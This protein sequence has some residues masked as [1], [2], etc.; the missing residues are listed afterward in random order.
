M[1]PFSVLVSIALGLLAP[2]L[3]RW[4]GARLGRVLA[5]WPFALFLYFIR[6]APRL[7]E[8]EVL[9]AAYR[10]F[11]FPLTW[12]RPGS[13]GGSGSLD[14]HFGF[15]LDGLALLFVLLITGIGALVLF[16]AG[17]Y[18]S[19]EEDHP[20]FFAYLMLFIGAML[21]VVLAD[22]LLLLYT[23]WEATSVTS[24]LL[25]GF[26]SHRDESRKGALKALLVTA[27]GGLALLAGSVLML[28]NTG[29]ADI[30][31]ILANRETLHASPLYP[32]T[33]ILVLVGAFTK[34]AQVPFH[35]WLPNAMEAPTPVS[36]YLHSAAMVKAGIY[37]IARMSGMF[38]GST[39]WLLLL[40]I[41]GTTSL[42]LGSYLALRQTDL[43]AILAFSTIS[44][45]G[46]IVTLFGWGTP[47]AM[48]AAMFHIL[49]H[50][51]FKAAL[52]MTV[53]IVDHQTGSR[54]IRSLKGLGALMPVTAAISL[55]ASLALAGVPPLNGFITKEMYFSASLEAGAL[56]AGVPGGA[57]LGSLYPAL[58]VAGSLLTFVYSLTISLG[59]FFGRQPGARSPVGDRGGD[60]SVGE[61]ASDPSV[62]DGATARSVGDWATD[63]L[64]ER[65]TD[66]SFGL[67]F[68]PA[69][70]A[71]GAVALGL[72]PAAVDAR[73]VASAARAT[74]GQ[75]ADTPLLL[76][77]GVNTPLLMSLAVMAGGL[78]G[79]VRRD[80]LGR[81]LARIP[82]RFNVNALYDW[83]LE[84]L[85]KVSE[86]VEAR[87]LTGF[88]RDYIA[89]LLGFFLA[90]LT[91]T[92]V[93]SGFFPLRADW[94][95]QGALEWAELL[96]ATLMA[97][98]ALCI[99]LVRSRVASVIA[100][101]AVG[102]GMVMLWTLF[103]APDLALSMLV[104]ETVT[105]LLFLLVFVYLPR[106]K[107]DVFPRGVQRV[108]LLIAG[109]AGLAV[110]LLLLGVRGIRDGRPIA[111]W[112]LENSLAL[113]GGR[114]VVNV[115]L[116]DFRGFDTMFE[117]VV[118]AL[119]GL[120][121]FII[122]NLRFKGGPK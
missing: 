45:L 77:H 30:S 83:G 68:P 35:L 86:F 3:H 91:F 23:F 18:L 16:Y 110:T 64:K 8:G 69:L 97:G 9:Q 37:L 22:N 63:R 44:Q 98:V 28:V 58:A 121:V 79:H 32:V 48:T 47:L 72:F 57:V 50:S 39:L 105:L 76:W 33:L 67:W 24:F 117:I 119:A 1:L 94:P 93:M 62:E 122:S 108:N 90:L 85:T 46:L 87:L 27:G 74:L 40:S 11:S 114:N 52:F 95:P 92:V 89:Y 29:S 65:I 80:A 112:Y 42:V 115:I 15:S 102:T 109:G 6:L 111:D 55:I 71:A 107:R 2:V 34:S 12:L 88:T 36:A 17:H 78:I 81:T 10:W 14:I 31:T 116:V 103:R 106:L 21:G 41:V 38:G 101:G 5:L 113:A 120:G 53:G 61:R 75:A 51:V 100:L 73:I 20:K 19:K 60:P 96:F 49:N 118:L 66:P 13:G 26:W 25:I 7:A 70:L 54:D 84:T 99:P 56:L 104:V 4:F 59:V 82:T 43:K